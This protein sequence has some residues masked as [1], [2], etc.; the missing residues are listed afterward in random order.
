MPGEIKVYQSLA[1]STLWPTGNQKTRLKTLHETGKGLSG[2]TR[3]TSYKR[4]HTKGESRGRTLLRKIDVS[5]CQDP[6]VAFMVA[7]L[8]FVTP[9][10]R[11]DSS[12]QSLKWVIVQVRP[13]IAALQI[14]NE[15]RHVMQCLTP[16][17]Y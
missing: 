7:H 12:L 5:Q 14:G 10:R 13:P 3:H 6:R 17:G 2:V 1:T 4:W 8:F 9:D 15:R 11:W 16:R